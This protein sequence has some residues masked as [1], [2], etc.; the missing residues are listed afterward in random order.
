MAAICISLNF[1]FWLIQILLNFVPEI[2]TSND[3]AL[4][5]EMACPRT[6]DKPFS[7]PMMV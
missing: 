4:I 2:P 3:S 6:G 1:V 5:Q 7:E